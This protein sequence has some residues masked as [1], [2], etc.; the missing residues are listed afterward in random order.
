MRV[1]RLGWGSALLLWAVGVL[2]ATLE[3]RVD[4]PPATGAVVAWVFD[5]PNTFVDLRDPVRTVVFPERGATPGLI[6]DLPAGEYALV[7]FH[8]ANSNGTLDKNFIGI[9][10]EWLGFSNRYWPEGPPTFARAAFRL[11]EN[12]TKT[13]DVHLRSIFGKIGLL[14][15][16]VGVIAQTS[17]YQ[18][19]K[20]LI[21]QPIPAISYI[22]DRVQILGPGVRC[23]LLKWKDLGLAATAEYRLG[24]YDE[25]DSPVLVGLG[26]RQSTLMGGLAFQAFLPGGVDLSAGY[27]TDLLG[28]F[29]GGISRLGVGKSFQGGIFTLTPRVGINRLSAALANYEFGVPADKA[30]EGRPSFL[31][32]AV[33]HMDYGLGLFIELRGAWRIILRG[34]LAPLPAELTESPIV[35]KS[36]VF[37]GFAAINR[38]F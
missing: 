31:P 36:E 29:N 26:D 16:G 12:E 2:G 19:S 15:V 4:H 11:E 6:M 37:S 13:I 5:S 35:G 3:V 30:Q 32:G 8:D 33:T 24:A 23:G 27:D 14:G 10:R 20:R 38:L 18:G 22:G 28:R 21:V 25:E 9:P 7:V 34:T 1:G 17:P